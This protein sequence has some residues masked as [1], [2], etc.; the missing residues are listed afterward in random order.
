MANPVNE[1]NWTTKRFH[2]TMREAF[3]NDA[4]YACAI[5]VHKPFRCLDFPI[6]AVVTGLAA[7]SAILMILAS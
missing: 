4:K 5:E 1:H 7:V 6:F 2:R 3:P